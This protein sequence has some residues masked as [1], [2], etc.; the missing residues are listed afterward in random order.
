MPEQQNVGVIG[1]GAMGT[2]I[3]RNLCKAGHHVTVYNR[4]RSRAEELA[5]DGATVAETVYEAC[6][7]DV[8][9]T[10]LSDDA[11][12]Q[13][14][15]LDDPN[16]IPSLSEQTVHVSMATISAGLAERLTEAHSQAGRQYVSAPVFGRPDAAAAAKLSIVAGGS[17]EAIERC[18]PVFDSIGQRTFH[19]GEQPVMANLIKIMGNFMI[20]STLETMGEAF[21]TL[22][23]YEV[24]PETFLEVITNTLF[25]S[26]V[27]KNYG[28]IIAQERFSPP[29]FK[30]PLGLKDVNLA[31]EAAAARQVPM[32]T[33]SLVHDQF[34]SAMGRGYGELDWAA[35][36][37][38]IAENAGLAP[39]NKKE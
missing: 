28:A 19:V 12:L 34:L 37:L 29:G 30:M 13:A 21:A 10:L 35:L 36:A 9:I 6:G 11:A 23:K 24:E 5:A 33:A 1:L 22:R 2:P 16:F 27:H 3:A 15:A 18:T 7:G 39:R 31:L 26:P 8:V 32:P 25:S 14:L 4:T 38:V 17:A 20:A